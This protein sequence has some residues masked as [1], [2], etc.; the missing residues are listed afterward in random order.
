MCPIGK[1]ETMKFGKIK[2]WSG[3]GLTTKILIV[4]LTL[5]IVS[6]AVIGSLLFINVRGVG[7]YALESSIFLGNRAVTD[8]TNALKD[9]AE[10]YL[11]RLAKDQAA[12]SNVLFEKVEAEI[13]TVAKFA[14]NLWSN[15]SSFKYRRSYSQK[16]KPDD[17]YATSVYVLAP[18]VAVDAVRK[19]LKLLS[20][21]DDI[22]IPVYASDP[23]LVCVGIGTE[24]GIYRAYPWFSEFPPLYD[25][26]KRGY[27]QKAAKA[28]RIGW[29]E[30]Y[31][32][33]FRRGLMITCFKP[34][35]NS[36]GKLVGVVAA[37]VTLKTMNEKIINTQVGKL[38]Y[39]FLI[40]DKGKI[41]ARPGL[42]AGDKRWD[43][44]F[45]TE[46]LLHS[47]NPE[48]KKIAE[49][50]TT[51]NTGIATCKFEGGEKYIGYA[52]ITCANWSIGIVMP[53]KEIIASA[54]AT[55]SQI[56]SATK[57]TEEGIEGKINSTQN[58]FIGIFITILLVVVGL[59]FLLSRTITRPILK[60]THAAQAMEKGE[61][62][63]QEI[64]SLSQ[65]KGE[66]EV[67]SLSRVFASMAT[68]VK[69]RV[70]R[71]K[72]QVEELQ[73]R[74]DESKKAKE[75]AKITESDYFQS[76]QETAKKMREKSKEK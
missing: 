4:F 31:V 52:P 20:N 11:L 15:P 8:S 59:V 61:L 9:Q 36:E 27:Y 76:L 42:S 21:V 73:I 74:V 41:I 53:V 64:A 22:F 47:H 58:T 17:I 26:R 67:A 63:E 54:L 75:V 39:V 14:S 68:Q 29:T 56:S 18:G 62:G 19:E 1:S 45:K 34:V 6:L 16:E 5:S 35:Y 32:D 70:N 7:N 2:F 33:A 13:N 43:E 51:G 46:N 49:N 69:A 44:S 65:S 71:L 30:L 23:N 3:F 28:D 37:D 60:V 25:P 38:G 10:E 55:R 12:I 72:R 66:D 48:L 57:D 40:D 50:M 24:S